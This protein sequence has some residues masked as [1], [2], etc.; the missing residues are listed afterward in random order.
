MSAD[1]GSAPPLGTAAMLLGLLLPDNGVIKRNRGVSRGDAAERHE[2]PPKQKAA[3][4]KR[5]NA[6][7]A[8]S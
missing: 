7:D 3:Y 6:D 2:A 8:R 1:T 4:P 5:N